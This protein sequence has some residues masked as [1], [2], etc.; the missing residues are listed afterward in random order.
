MSHQRDKEEKR[1][2]ESASLPHACYWYL[3]VQELGESDDA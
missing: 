2:I 3:V 1:I